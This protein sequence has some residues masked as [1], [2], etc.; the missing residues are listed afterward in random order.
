MGSF[1][2]HGLE[3]LLM[4]CARAE[5]TLVVVCGCIP[6]LKPLYDFV[7]NGTSLGPSDLRYGSGPNSYKLNSSSTYGTGSQSAHSR[8]NYVAK[9]DR[10]DRDHLVEHSQRQGIKQTRSFGVEATN[11][12]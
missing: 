1:H 6:A 2:L 4:L 8:S 10:P 12:V 9:V 7:V 5:V 11:R 3:I